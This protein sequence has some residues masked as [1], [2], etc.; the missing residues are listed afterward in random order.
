[1]SFKH[2]LLQAQ[3]RHQP[4]QLRVLLLQLFQP[5]RLIHLQPAVLL[6]P[7]V[8]GLL[9]DPGLLACLRRRLPV[10]DRHFNLPQQVH[11]L[12]RRMLLSSCHIQLLLYQFLSSQLVQKLPGTPL[13]GRD[14]GVVIV[15]TIGSIVLDTGGYEVFDLKGAK[16]GERME[17]KAAASSDLTG[18]DTMTD[19]HFA[20]FI[21]AIQTGEK[22]TQ[23]IESGNI[24]VTMLQL[25]NVAWEVQRELQLDPATGHVL[26]DKEAMTLWGRDY[27]KGWAPHL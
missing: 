25:S 15:G 7:P 5:P 8:V 14:R 10:R 12:L 3:L 24:S 17:G 1:M 20:N 13:Y 16:T 9:R 6:A 21:A 2:Q 23:P 26:N 18:A 27:E 11:H 22:L 4:L 19:A